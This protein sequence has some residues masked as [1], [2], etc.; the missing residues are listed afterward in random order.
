MALAGLLVW[1]RV[2]VAGCSVGCL[3]WLVSQRFVMALYGL[4]LV[5]FP[6]VMWVG[7]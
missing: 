3:K 5:R 1:G 2:L 6:R 7:L 4:I